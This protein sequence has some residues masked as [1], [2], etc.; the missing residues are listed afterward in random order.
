M[1]PTSTTNQE[2]Q[3]STVLGRTLGSMNNEM[4]L[5]TAFLSYIP[6]SMD[7]HTANMLLSAVPTFE[8]LVR[9]QNSKGEPCS[10]GFVR[11]SSI[12]SLKVVSEIFSKID[13]SAITK[14]KFD[15]LFKVTIDE[16]TQRYLTDYEATH[17]PDFA[18][19][20]TGKTLEESVREVTTKLKSWYQINEAAVGNSL[21]GKK[22]EVEEKKVEEENEEDQVHIDEDDFLDVPIEQREEVLAEIKEFRVLSIKYEKVKH[23]K[24]AEETKEREKH[25]EAVASKALEEKAVTEANQN[26]NESSDEGS[27]YDDDDD[28][29]PE[30]DEQLE[31][32]RTAR[33]E[34]RVDKLFEESQRRWLGRERLRNSALERERVRDEDQE[35]RLERDKRQAYR[36]YEDFKDNG[37]YETRT[38]EYYYDHSKWVKAR[39]QFRQR[40][41]EQ[42][43]RDA[44]DEEIEQGEKKSNSENFMVSLAGSL[45]N[46]SSV[47]GSSAAG[48]IKLSLGGASKKVSVPFKKQAGVET[49]LDDGRDAAQAKPKKLIK[50]LNYGD[51]HISIPDDKET[52]FAWD[53][54]WDALNENTIEDSLKPFI[55]NT[56]VEYLGVQEDDLI[57]FVV[58]HIREHKPP[59]ELVSELEMALDED[60]E[61]FARKVWKLLVTETEMP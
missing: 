53:V 8:F 23:E 58:Q 61:V 29:P 20:I 26:A 11:Y 38:M 22:D 43:E 52:L 44:R 9:V 40:E 24:T 5:R 51:G 13:Y 15:T 14:G 30:S 49:L 60:A 33:R 19:K 12:E 45:Q 10:F 16:N 27:D 18:S 59:A 37:E 55:T 31:Q 54:K 46:Q 34:A 17:G 32:L 21:L 47:I 6:V 50:P 57:D 36:R 7:E 1:A 28:D 39:M 25:L 42:D 2:P 56:I 35:G 3:I 4:Q 48:K 41:I